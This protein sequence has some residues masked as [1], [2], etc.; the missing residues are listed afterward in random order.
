MTRFEYQFPQTKYLPSVTASGS[1]T[2]LPATLRSGSSRGPSGRIH[3]DRS[4]H[5]GGG[6]GPDSGAAAPATPSPHQ[7]PPAS[8]LDCLTESDREFIEAVTGEVI[9]PGQRPQDRPVSPFAMQL[10]VDR[11]HGG[12]SAGLEVSGAYLRRTNRLLLRLN[13]PT[14][15]FSGELLDRALDYV[16]RKTRSL[17]GLG[18]SSERVPD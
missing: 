3:P 10:A 4:G 11:Q 5:S 17:M 8:E 7:G 16:D 2:R 1:T 9:E 12:L 15:P 6:T 13:V 18:G 14:N